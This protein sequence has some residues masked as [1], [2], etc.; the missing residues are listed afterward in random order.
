AD[1]LGPDD[2]FFLYRFSDEPVLLQ[3]WTHD[4][5]AISRALS[6]AVP[7]GRTAMFDTVADAIPL[8][9]KGHNRK[10]A[11]VVIS[12]GNDTSSHTTVRE[13]KQLIRESE[14]LVYAVGIDC[15]VEPRR[16]FGGGPFDQRRGPI[17]IPFPMPPGRRP[18]PPPPNY[19]PPTSRP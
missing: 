7:A 11:L 2:E 16:S 1:L 15:G 8:A 6:R 13:V 3:D 18:L 5:A 9:Q 14:T 10:K 19:P 17:P 12:D 4:R